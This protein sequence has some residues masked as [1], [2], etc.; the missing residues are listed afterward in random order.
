MT[1]IKQ[2][3][4]E[5][6]FIE[7]IEA[8]S[9]DPNL[10]MWK[11]EDK[12]K[13]IKNGAQLT[14]RESQQALFL[15][16]GQLADVF[17]AGKYELKTENIPVLSRLKGWKYGFE[18]PFKADVYFFNTQ[19]FIN[20][21]WGTPAPVLLR[22]PQ[23]GQ[24]RV[25][26]FGSF[27]LRIADVSA[28]FREYTGTYKQLTIFELQAQLRDFIASRF[29]QVLAL[30]GLSVMD[31]AGNLEE[32][33]RKMEPEIKPY[34]A[35]LGIELTRF[36]ITSVTLPDEVAAHY[37]KITNMNMVT[38]MDKFTRFNT[39]TAIGQQG[40]AMND[41]VQGAAMMGAMLSQMPVN[42]TGQPAQAPSETSLVEKLKT[43]KTLFD[44]ELIDEAEYKAKKETL[45]AGL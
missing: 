42:N 31:V 15:N 9:A 5:L 10:M 45:L 3:P 25:R 32:L 40:T 44:A 7:I 17:R 19:Q 2:H 29:A 1:V 27:D 6:P 12:D 11:F 30:E 13:E 23:F 21:K 34:L 33:S 37:D 4:M 39:A 22:D 16:E 41:G 26:A 20:N 35:Q 28:F 38:D 43:L 14:V 8:A 18:S 24:V 36:V